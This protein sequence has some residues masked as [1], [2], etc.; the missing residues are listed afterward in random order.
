MDSFVL[1]L[2]LF[3]FPASPRPDRT[4]CRVDSSQVLTLDSRTSTLEV[5]MSALGPASAPAPGLHLNSVPPPPN[6]QS[7]PCSLASHGAIYYFFKVFTAA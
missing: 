4:F 6:L 3:L 1:F 5:H 7:N 2:N